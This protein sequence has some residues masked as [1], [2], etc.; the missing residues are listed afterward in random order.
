VAGRSLVEDDER[1]TADYAR[2]SPGYFE[3]FRIPMIR[4]RSF[5]EADR[6]GRAPVAIV[7]ET[8]AKRAW[9]GESPIGRRVRLGELDDA[10]LEIVGTAR[11]AK[12]RTLTE[13]PRAMIYV[14]FEQ[15][16]DASMVLVARVRETG[17]D[18]SSALREIVRDLDSTIPIVANTPYSDLMSVALL[19]SRAAAVSATV[20]GTLGLVLASLGLYGVLAFAVSERT[21]EIG[22]RMALGAEP[23]AVRSLVLVNGVRLAAM[24]LGIGVAFALALTRLLRSLLYGLSPTDPITFGAVV[25]LLLVVALAASYAPALRA[26]RTD[27]VEALRGQA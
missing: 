12:Y 10:D 6:E 23:G 9:P 5:T 7:N 20:F 18:V 27:P 2:V 26:T 21:R 17:A 22:I 3:A 11:N 15:W 1:P 19:P 8:F 13:S 25:L 16:P 4:G 14:P 24:G